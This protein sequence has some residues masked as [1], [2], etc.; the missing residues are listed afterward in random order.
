MI[1][2]SRLRP[3][4]SLRHDL[5]LPRPR[6]RGRPGGRSRPPRRPRAPGPA[7]GPAPGPRPGCARLSL[8]AVSSVRG[9]PAA[10]SARSRPSAA[11]ACSRR[12]QKI[13]LAE[14]GEPGRVVPVPGPQFGRR[15]RPWPSHPAGSRPCARR[16]ARSGR[17]AHGRRP[18]PRAHRRRG[19]PGHRVAKPDSPPGRFVTCAVLPRRSYPRFRATPLP[20]GWPARPPRPGRAAGRGASAAPGAPVSGRASRTEI[21]T[22]SPRADSR[23]VNADERGRW[24]WRRVRSPPGRRHRRC[25]RHPSRAACQP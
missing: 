19:G 3:A 16:A 22:R 6:I 11:R 23:I 4:R 1:M 24:H 12:A 13:T 21:R 2:V 7:A 20:S 5:R 8:V 25:P 10:A 17:R 18:R 9:L 14:L 15:A